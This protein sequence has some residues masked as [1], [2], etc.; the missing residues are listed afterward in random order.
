MK[1]EL[2]AKLIDE[3]NNLTLG[4]FMKMSEMTMFLSPKKTRFKGIY[5]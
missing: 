4:Y 5:L 2:H 1:N 3:N